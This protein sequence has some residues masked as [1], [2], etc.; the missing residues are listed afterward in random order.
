MEAP[1]LAWCETH[2]C[3]PGP[4]PPS[5]LSLSLTW[6]FLRGHLLP[7][8]LRPQNAHDSL[9]LRKDQKFLI[10]ANSHFFFFFNSQAFCLGW[11]A[12]R[13][14]RGCSALPPTVLSGSQSPCSFSRAMDTKKNTH[15]G[16]SRHVSRSLSDLHRGPRA[17]QGPRGRAPQC[18][19]E[20]SP[21]SSSAGPNCDPPWWTLPSTANLLGKRV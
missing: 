13:Q 2:L 21:S 1:Q 17:S 5:L 7:L 19:V 12:E 14:L 4:D 6:W 8:T 9:N 15:H 10:R 11:L 16:T 3:V 20:A 18:P